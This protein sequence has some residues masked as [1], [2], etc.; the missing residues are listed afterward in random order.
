MKL[1]LEFVNSRIDELQR[2]IEVVQD[3]EERD[4][5]IQTLERFQKIHKVLVDYGKKH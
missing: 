3:Y 4:R 2:Q 5:L 1:E